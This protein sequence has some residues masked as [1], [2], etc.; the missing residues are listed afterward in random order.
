M[1]VYDSWR[2]LYFCCL[3]FYWLFYLSEISLDNWCKHSNFIDIGSFFN[4]TNS[5]SLR[6]C[7]STFLS[8]SVPFQLESEGPE[9]LTPELIQAGTILVK[10]AKLTFQEVL[11]QPVYLVNRYR[12]FM[13]TKGLRI[14]NKRDSNML[15][16]KVRNT[17][18][19]WSE[20]WGFS[21]SEILTFQ[22]YTFHDTQ[23]TKQWGKDNVTQ[24][25]MICLMS[26]IPLISG[27]RDLNYSS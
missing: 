21:S 13:T 12:A 3:F 23:H 5:R 1:N 22:L 6:S 14:E 9:F 24:Y 10:G 26:Q 16:K 17:L 18:R 20:L 7:F 2:L 19:V 27:N 11:P 15:P 4:H 8:T 25:C